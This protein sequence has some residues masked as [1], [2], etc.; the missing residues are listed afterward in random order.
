MRR[1]R[2]PSQQQIRDASQPIQAVSPIVPKEVL[3]RIY[4]DYIVTLRDDEPKADDGFH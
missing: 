4:A 1:K 3:N 2:A